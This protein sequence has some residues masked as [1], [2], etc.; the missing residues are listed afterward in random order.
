MD[1]LEQ[2]MAAL[3]A[4]VRR[5]RDHHDINQMIVSYGP[6]ADTA[7][8]IERTEMLAD[9]WVEDGLYDVGGYFRPKGH[10][11]LAQSYEGF[12]F[13]LVKNGVCHVMMPPYIRIDGDRAVA[14]NYSCVFRR[15]GE[16]RFYVWRASAN[17][18]E[19]VRTAD[20][21]K[22]ETRIN[23]PMTG[24]PEALAMMRGIDQLVAQ[25]DRP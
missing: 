25:T 5:L 12:H 1:N 17:R 13:D 22:I 15:E 20:G 21:W 16:E 14:L 4:E 6:R 23:R 8:D 24:D 10:K 11:E 18:W 2:R 9:M 3:E 19:L 7:N